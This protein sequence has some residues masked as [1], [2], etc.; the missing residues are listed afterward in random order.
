MLTRIPCLVIHRQQDKE[1]LPVIQALE[2]GLGLT[3]QQV[4]GEDGAFLIERGIPQ[5]HP[6]SR[7]VTTPG[8]LGCTA[9]HC[10]ILD[11]ALRSAFEAVCIFEDD[12]EMMC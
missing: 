11:G 8:N 4:E 9:S 7:E 5:K 6:L 12:A 10:K 2:E 3:L 1:R